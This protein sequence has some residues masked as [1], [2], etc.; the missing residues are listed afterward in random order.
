MLEF[1]E[2]MEDFHAKK[3]TIIV[4]LF[5]VG[6]RYSVMMSTS[7]AADAILERIVYKEH[8]KNK[9]FRKKYLV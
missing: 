7:S 5:Y 2:L 6:I 1:L 8:I 9:Y 4:N 3:S